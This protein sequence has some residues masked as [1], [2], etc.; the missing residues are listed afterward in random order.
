MSL[1][2]IIILSQ[3]SLIGGI[4]KRAKKYNVTYHS[5]LEN[6][7]QYKT[8]KGNDYKNFFSMAQIGNFFQEIE[9][10]I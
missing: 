4:M 8:I 7:P 5:V 1:F 3:H 10:G 2:S 9:H 6:Y